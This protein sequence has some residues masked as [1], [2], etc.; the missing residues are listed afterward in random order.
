VSIGL[1]RLFEQSRLDA[2]ARAIPEAPDAAAAF[3]ELSL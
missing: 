3:E 2:F 1:R